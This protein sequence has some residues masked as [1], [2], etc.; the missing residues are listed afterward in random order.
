MNAPNNKYIFRRC[1]NDVSAS[2]ILSGMMQL[3]PIFF[4]G[5]IFVIRECIFTVIIHFIVCSAS[6]ISNTV[7]YTRFFSRFEAVQTIGLRTIT[8]MPT[9]LRNSIL[10]NQ[11]KLK[12]IKQNI[13]SQT[14]AMFHRFQTSKYQHIQEIGRQE[15][16]FLIRS[17]K[18][19]PLDWTQSTT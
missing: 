12:S 18:T 13:V 9:Y 15:T 16:S 11:S 10:L 4:D 14:K 8:G 5:N 17:P 2:L 1:L 7:W 19:R 6:P 3:S